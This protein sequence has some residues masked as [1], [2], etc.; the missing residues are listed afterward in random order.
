MARIRYA[1]IERLCAD[2]VGMRRDVRLDTAVTAKRRAWVPILI[3]AIGALVVFAAHFRPWEGGLLEEWAI[4]RDLKV[5]GWWGLIENYLEWSLSRPLHLVPTMLGLAAGGGEPAGIFLVMGLVAMGQYLAV[6]WALRPIS[7]ST[8]VNVAVALFVGLHPL[9]AAGYLQR[10]LPA[11]TS[12][13]ALM[14]ALGF[15][16]RW[17]QQGRARWLVGVCVSLMLGFAAYQGPAAVAPVMALALALALRAGWRRG[18]ALV[19]AATASSAAMAAYAIVVVRLV[20]PADQDS[21]ELINIAA[22]GVSGPGELIRLVAGTF[23]SSGRFLVLGVLAVVLLAAILSLTRT[24]PHEAGWVMAG[25]ALTSPVCAVVYFGNTAWLSDIDRVAFTTSLALVVALVIWP[26]TARE[27]QRPL[28]TVLAAVLIVVAMVGGLL[29]VATWQP[30]VRVQHQLLSALEPVVHEATGDETVV[31]VD[32]S[33]TFGQLYTLPLGYINGASMI[34]NDDATD[35]LLCL[36]QSTP[37]PVPP[38]NVICDPTSAGF[39]LRPAGTLTLPSGDVDFFIGNVDSD[40][41]MKGYR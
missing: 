21:Y 17:L 13:L 39:D 16:I 35:V 7:R 4:A 12:A 22:A 1:T 31:V 24:I 11:Q 14:I 30:F 6:I 5:Y 26:L 10:F 36:P 2:D 15:M 32:H 20:T 27:H 19:V 8:W 37:Y 38:G 34:S 33:G 40:E 3:V 9:W 25:V 23:L 18:I 28:Q 29:G 41:F